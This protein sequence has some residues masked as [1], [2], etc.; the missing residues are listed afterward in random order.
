MKASLKAYMNTLKAETMP[1]FPKKVMD[2]YT[3]DYKSWSEL[4]TKLKD[5][6]YRAQ[7]S[8]AARGVPGRN[9]PST[10][11]RRHEI[12]GTVSRVPSTTGPRRATWRSSSRSAS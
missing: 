9:G 3:A 2:F 5:K 4:E 7:A 11:P 1:P 12:C 6:D 8:A 10:R